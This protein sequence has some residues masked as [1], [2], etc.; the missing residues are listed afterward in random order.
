MVGP[1]TACIRIMLGS[2]PEVA[3]KVF[4]EDIRGCK[5]RVGWTVFQ[6]MHAS[7][8]T[9]QC[10]RILL[11]KKTTRC[12]VWLLSSLPF[13]APHI[14]FVQYYSWLVDCTLFFSHKLLHCNGAK[15]NM[16]TFPKPTR[17]T[18]SKVKMGG[19]VMPLS[20]GGGQC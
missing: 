9:S 6:V 17:M 2:R 14:L 3:S 7:L 11:G 18:K 1:K 13:V 4:R 16:E 10:L 12:C 5:K 19:S 15:T 20:L 8:N